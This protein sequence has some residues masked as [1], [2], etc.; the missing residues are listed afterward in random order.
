MDMAQAA[1]LP[2]PPARLAFAAV[3]LRF[4]CL[5]EAE[6]Q[7][8]F[9]PF[10]HFR[11]TVS[12]TDVGHINFRVG[13]TDHI[14]LYAGHIGYQVQERFRGGGYAFQACRAL[15]PF[16]RKIYREVIITADPDN[17]PSL[18]T[19]ERLGA[20][21]IDQIFFPAGDPQ[22]GKASRVKNRFFWKPGQVLPGLSYAPQQRDQ[23]DQKGGPGA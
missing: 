1:P 6:L 10:Y 17:Q 14:R 11:I 7:R 20:L 18:R 3:S 19:I 5:S 22:Y 12:S 13:E 23:T 21:F 4:E 2:T 16:I 15:E 8:G 9:V